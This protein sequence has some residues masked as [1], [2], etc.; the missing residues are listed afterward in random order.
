[1][2]GRMMNNSEIT[3]KR[4][5]PQNDIIFKKIFGTKGN[6]GILK[7]FLESIATGTAIFAR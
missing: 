7:D 3:E 5:T 2:K 1:M 4:I 6:E